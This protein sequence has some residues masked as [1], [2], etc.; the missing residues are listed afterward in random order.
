MSTVYCTRWGLGKRGQ[1]EGWGIGWNP[2][3]I[4]PMVFPSHWN[5]EM[6]IQYNL[7]AAFWNNFHPNH[8]SPSWTLVPMNVHDTFASIYIISKYSSGTLPLFIFHMFLLLIFVPH[9]SH[10]FT[11]LSHVF[12]SSR[13]LIK[14]ILIVVV[15]TQLILVFCSSFIPLNPTHWTPSCVPWLSQNTQTKKHDTFGAQASWNLHVH[16]E[17]RW[18]LIWS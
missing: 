2:V 7:H 12:I 10:S 1:E 4:A 3:Y 11:L 17:G 13:L 8:H 15:Q 14:E 9:V 6:P 5:H 18:V 16:G